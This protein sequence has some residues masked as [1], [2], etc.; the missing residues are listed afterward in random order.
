[1][2]HERIETNIGQVQ[3]PEEA[4][5]NDEREWG[6]DYF[7][8]IVRSVE[9]SEVSKPGP[10]EVNTTS[11]L[12][13][14][15]KVEFTF[16]TA[17]SPIEI[18]SNGQ[19]SGHAGN[20]IIDSRI[21]DYVKANQEVVARRLPYLYEYVR[22]ME[23]PDTKEI[24]EK[25]LGD[26][27]KFSSA[28]LNMASRLE[29]S[30]V[31]NPESVKQLERLARRFT[32][33]FVEQFSISLGRKIKSIEDFDEYLPPRDLNTCRKNLT[34][35]ERL[36][37]QA[38][39]GKSAS[40]ALSHF[41]NGGFYS[42]LASNDRPWLKAKN[43]GEEGKDFISDNTEIFDAEALSFIIGKDQASFRREVIQ[44]ILIANI[45][46]KEYRNYL[47]NEGYKKPVAVI[48]SYEGYTSCDATE[49]KLI[50]EAKSGSAL[51]LRMD[52]PDGTTALMGVKFDEVVLGVC[53][54][55]TNPDFSVG[56][57]YLPIKDTYEFL[58]DQ[59][60][61]YVRVEY[62]E[63]DTPLHVWAT[64]RTTSYSEVEFSKVKRLLEDSEASRSHI[65]PK[66]ITIDNS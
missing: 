66:V 5:K 47:K 12:M 65:P 63:S 44:S 11:L 54:E 8:A 48:P 3:G 58:M 60:S 7:E 1:M 59:K 13:E 20:V 10:D 37:M 43:L 6:N 19:D 64:N 57:S 45:N 26:N 56:I 39:L 36:N 27:N 4:P 16:G 30:L 61:P 18:Y 52:F 17:A 21:V 62:S 32:P 46:R 25:L 38:K 28:L 34:L 40:T 55:S 23:E 14:G 49:D 29:R 41:N 2:S 53:I 50:T 35:E 24:L 31:E 9:R 22:L 42:S 51:S 33:Q 15:S